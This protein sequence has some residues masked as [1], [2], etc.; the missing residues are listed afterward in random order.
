[1]QPVYS[2]ANKTVL[3]EIYHGE[4]AQLVE[5]HHHW[6]RREDYWHIGIN[7]TSDI[8]NDGVLDPLILVGSTDRGSEQE[9]SYNAASDMWTVTFTATNADFGVGW[10][11]DAA[12]WLYWYGNLEFTVTIQKNS[13]S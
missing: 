12:C 1:M 3:T 2:E 6:G 4:V 5:L 13:S 11:D 8:D 9:G 10:C 7:W